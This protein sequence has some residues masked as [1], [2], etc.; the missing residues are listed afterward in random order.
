MKQEQS[1]EELPFPW[2]LG[3]YDAHCHPTDTMTSIDDIPAMNAK[4]LTIM[5]TREQDQDL[6]S[7]VAF[8]HGELGSTHPNSVRNSHSNKPVNRILPCFGWHPWFSH[9]VFDD[10]TIDGHHNSP[11]NKKEHY[12]AVLTPSI[13]ENEILLG[14]LPAPRSLSSLISDTKE[15][16]WRHPNALVGEIGLDR[17]FRIPNTWHPDGGD[18]DPSRTAGTREGRKLSPHRVQLAHQ[19]VILKAQL[20]LAGDLRRA[21]SIHSVQAHGAIFDILQELWSG[22]EKEVISSRQRKRRVS[23]DRAHDDESEEE[24]L[25]DGNMKTNKERKL[26]G[27]ISLP[28]PPR[29]CMHSYS[30]PVEPLKQFLHPSVPADIY[31]SFSDVINFSSDSFDRVVEVI[32]ALPENRILV[33]SDLHCAGKPM[34]DMLEQIVRRI[35]SIRGW[36]LDDGVRIL[37]QNWK[38]FAFDC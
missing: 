33:E 21:V 30:G 15:R 31:F 12:K 29:I 4:A 6:V 16:L 34:D 25:I 9:M 37:G 10:T 27:G 36:G 18:K 32:K 38:R 5:A 26:Y 28:F 3:V 20:K 24:S 14:E 23:V 11:V 17:S 22:Y 1:N 13:E 7:K 2:E 19:K 8:K 35:C